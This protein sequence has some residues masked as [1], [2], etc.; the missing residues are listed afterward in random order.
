MAAGLASVGADVLDGRAPFVLFRM[1]DAV[2]VRKLLH[3]KG[4]AVRRGD[5][6]VGLDE[7]YLR[8]AV[9]PEWPLLVQAIAETQ[10]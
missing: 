5:T 9:R 10:R 8:A 2:R 7:R 6:F 4:I 3:D 1:P